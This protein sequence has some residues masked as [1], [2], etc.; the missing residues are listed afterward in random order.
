MREVARFASSD[1]DYIADILR[2]VYKV[3]DCTEDRDGTGDTSDAKLFLSEFIEALE[4]CD[5]IEIVQDSEMLI[6]E[7]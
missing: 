4:D 5:S 7:G 6:D 2:S 1:I 3:L